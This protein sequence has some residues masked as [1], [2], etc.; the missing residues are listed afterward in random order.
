M[1][2]IQQ[3]KYLKLK[4]YFYYYYIIIAYCQMSYDFLSSHVFIQEPNATF[5]KQTW[6][7]F[8]DVPQRQ[9]NTDFQGGG[10]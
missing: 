6:L 2:H 1:E 4:D 10:C 7:T 5:W 8:A 3:L 9:L